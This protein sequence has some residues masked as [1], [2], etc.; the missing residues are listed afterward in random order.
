MAVFASLKAQNALTYEE[1]STLELDTLD[2]IAKIPSGA[3][4]THWSYYPYLD[5]CT[6]TDK[7]GILKRFLVCDGFMSLTHARGVNHKQQPFLTTGDVVDQMA[8]VLVTPTSD[9]STYS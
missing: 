4:V 6:V 2:N 3:T 8:R 9:H 1:D 5:E 7:T